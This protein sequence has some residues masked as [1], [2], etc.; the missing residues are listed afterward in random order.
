MRLVKTI[1]IIYFILTRYELY[2]RIEKLWIKIMQDKNLNGVFCYYRG[3]YQN[4]N[5]K[6]Y[7]FKNQKKKK[8]LLYKKNEYLIVWLL[9]YINNEHLVPSTAHKYN[10]EITK[11]FV[12]S[13]TLF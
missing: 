2:R 3:N 13:M 12:D 4:I 5:T 7:I 9:I 8:D 11:M 6:V 1:Y 10:M